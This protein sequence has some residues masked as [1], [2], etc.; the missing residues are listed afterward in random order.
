MARKILV[1][2][3]PE[4]DSR[5]KQVLAGERVSFV[6]TV[7]EAIAALKREDF[8][9]LLVSVHFDD[10]RMFDLLREVRIDGRNRGIPII[11]VREPELGFTAISGS[12]LEVT[13]R[14]LEADAFLDLAHMADEAER[15]AALRTALQQYLPISG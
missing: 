13:C 9:L 4:L 7:N 2:D 11:C 6:R 12:A 5:L 14:A 15:D 1:A 3:V 8:D 10:S